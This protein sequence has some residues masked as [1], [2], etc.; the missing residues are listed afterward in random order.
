MIYRDINNTGKVVVLNELKTDSFR[1]SV[2]SSM[3]RGSGMV[4]M[5]REDNSRIVVIKKIQDNV[6][7]N[8]SYGFDHFEYYPYSGG[9]ACMTKSGKTFYSKDYQYLIDNDYVLSTMC[10]SNVKSL[11]IIK[12]SLISEEEYNEISDKTVILWEDA[13]NFRELYPVNEEYLSDDYDEYDDDYEDEETEE[14]EEI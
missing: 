1:V 11:D 2:I 4:A 6:D 3:Y 12:V 14:L 7:T 9:V 5:V 8:C 10:H 13:V